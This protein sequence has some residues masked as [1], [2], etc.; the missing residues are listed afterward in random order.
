MADISDSD[1]H[2]TYDA[3]TIRLAN[4]ARLRRRGPFIEDHMTYGAGAVNSHV[5]QYWVTTE[6]GAATPYAPSA[7]VVNG[8]LVAVTGG[9]TN[10]AEE[11]AG[12]AVIWQPS[13]HGRAAGAEGLVLEVRAK[14]V[15]AT[16]ATDGDF[17]IGFADAVT[18]TNGLSFVVG[19]TSAYTTEAPVEFAGFH[20]SSIPTSGTLY[21]A[22]GNVIGCKT[23][24]NSVAGTVASSTVVKDSNYHTYHVT[25]DTAGNVIMYLDGVY[26]AAFPAAVTAA[27]AL[28]PYIGAIAKASHTLTATVDYIGVSGYIA[29]AA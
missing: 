29:D 14:F 4:G 7:S 22:S 6:T 28:T 27:T 25:I 23:M 3:K 18:Y 2:V 15:G 19:L 26:R 20:Y 11:L 12:K 8:A 9:T 5:P 16:T 13:T 10:N 1:K 24:K 17:V 21:S